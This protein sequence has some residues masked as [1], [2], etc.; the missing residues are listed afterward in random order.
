MRTSRDLRRIRIAQSL[1]WWQRTAIYQIYPRSF[2]DSN[3]DG[4]GD[5]QGVLRRIDH[6]T[7]LGIG[8][9][10]LSPIYPSPMLDFGYDICDFTGVDPQFGTLDDLDALI[11]ALHERD[12]RLI[13]DF[14]PNH[15]S[16]QHPWFVESRRS[17]ESPRR[18]WYVWAD[19]GPDGGPPN[20]WLSRFGGSAWHLDE[21]TGQYYY[22]AFLKEQPDLNWRNPEVRYAM[23]EV[24]RF[25][26]RRGVDGFRVD[27]SAVLAEDAL[28]RNDPPNPEYDE[29]TPPP[30]KLR[31][32]FTDDRPETLEYLA[33]LRRV[34]D[35]F[36]DRL[37]L[38]EVQGEKDRIARFYAIDHT[39]LLHLPLNFLLLDVDWKA[40]AVAAAMDEYLNVVPEDAWPDWVIGSHDKCRIATRVGVEQARIAAML[41]ITL[42]GTPILYSGDEIGM[43]QEPI[44]PD[45]IQDPFERLVPGYGL[46]RDPERAPMRWT[47]EEKAG[48]TTGEP[49]LPIGPK[50]R[51]TNVASQ[52]ADPHSLLAL[53]RSL[54]QLR[55]EE[56][57]LIAGRYEPLRT[58]G[59]VVMFRR[60]C[61]RDSILVALNLGA[62]SQQV[63]L[64]APG[65]VCLSTCLDRVDER[66][67]RTLSLRPN[68]GVVLKA[69]GRMRS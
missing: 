17:R 26:M 12:I 53:Y 11:H 7:W 34:V 9:V 4:I 61:D 56:P 27:A 65:H 39:R 10:W 50:F 33:E 2:Q 59:D 42:R 22:H 23:G 19:P 25:W 35:E 24:L 14:V 45:R 37:L 62:S 40:D 30:E 8:A 43:Q 44:P 54:L 5:L 57:A 66:V 18:D 3:G 55:G 28:L 47:D 49:W 29:H 68:E 21:G 46:N 36:D 1:A 58:H 41:A 64:A 6:L 48:F 32:V 63:D 13:L 60:C 15:T 69:R 31:R 51:E 16:D 52:R 67:E 38:G 20:N